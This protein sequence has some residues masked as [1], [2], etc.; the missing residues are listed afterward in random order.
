MVEGLFKCKFGV[1]CLLVD[2][3][4]VCALVVYHSLVCWVVVGR[5]CFVP[6]MFWWA[7][8]F[9]EVGLFVN[10]GMGRVSVGLYLV[11]CLFF[12]KACF[13]FR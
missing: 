5:G 3:C 10:V 6:K 9:S 2:P 12:D 13:A 8:A 4:G 7:S 11:D 1:K